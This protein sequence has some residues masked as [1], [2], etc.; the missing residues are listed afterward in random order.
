MPRGRRKYFWTPEKDQVLLHL[1]NGHPKQ[2]KRI[3]RQLASFPIWVIRRRA[4]ELRLTRIKEPRWTPRDEEFVR[5]HIGTRP[6]PKMAK[7]LGRTVVAV[8]LHTKRM[9]LRKTRIGLTA[10]SAAR[11]LGCDIHVV[12]RWIRKGW[13]PAVRRGTDRRP[14]QG[15]DAWFISPLHLRRVVIEHPE[16]VDLRRVDKLWFIDLLIGRFTEGGTV[17]VDPDRPAP[18]TVARLDVALRELAGVV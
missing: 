7:R 16:E 8:K 6:W 5:A 12:T 11:L 2:L 3:Y 1:Y 14:N 4:K 18:A 15:G 10:N 9:G 13:L 17:L